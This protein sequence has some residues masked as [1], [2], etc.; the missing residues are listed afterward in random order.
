MKPYPGTLEQ[1]SG[2]IFNYRLTRARRIVENTF[3]LCYVWCS[4]L[5]HF[6]ARRYWYNNCI[7]GV[8]WQC[9]CPKAGGSGVTM[10]K[11]PLVYVFLIHIASCNVHLLPTSFGKPCDNVRHPVFCSMPQICCMRQQA[12]VCNAPH[13]AERHA[14]CCTLLPRCNRG[15]S[16]NAKTLGL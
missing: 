3:G 16:R 2:R 15:F 9:V 12:A 13:E 4:K 7:V 5:L 6:K 11:M 1:S 8:T 14:A 10:W